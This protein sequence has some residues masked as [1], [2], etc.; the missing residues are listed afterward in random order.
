[1]I[2]V[3]IGH[4][5]QQLVYDQLSFDMTKKTSKNQPNEKYHV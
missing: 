4:A 5:L 2:L 1:M 3:Q